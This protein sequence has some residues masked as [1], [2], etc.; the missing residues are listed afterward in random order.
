MIGIDEYRLS[1]ALIYII[2]AYY[3]IHCRLSVTERARNPAR[4]CAKRHATLPIRKI[5][6]YATILRWTMTLSF[7]MRLGIHSGGAH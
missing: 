3:Y 1:I 6:D 4:L 7:N 5:V 2:M